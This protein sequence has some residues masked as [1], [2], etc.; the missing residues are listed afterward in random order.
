MP[1][2]SR[3]LSSLVSL[4][5]LVQGWSAEPPGDTSVFLQYSA[6]DGLVARA[7]RAVA[8]RRFGEAGSLLDRCLA[9]VPDHFEAHYLLARMAYEGRDYVG[10]LAHIERSERS[11]ADLDRRYREEMAALAAQAQAE[12]V[13]MQSS[14]DQLY[15]RGV[16]P[17]GCSAV[18][19][20]VKRNDLALLE[21]R[22]G[23]LYDR[24]NPFGIPADYHFL[25]GNCLYRLG[26]RDA[27]LAQYRLAVQQDRTHG[28]A[29]TNLIS[30]QWEAGAF[31]GARADLERA[32]AAHVAVRP[33]LKRAVLEGAK[34]APG[35]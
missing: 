7:S 9:K 2:R 6:L 5:A 34:A 14:L 10:A 15:A 17:T 25:H 30:L 26:R 27:A 18:L 13:A 20:Q 22:K 32:E 1:L 21:A 29:W 11:L 33:D 3:L 28:S 16:D 35:R 8:A 23:H 4:P 24:E 19:F 31:A 12:E